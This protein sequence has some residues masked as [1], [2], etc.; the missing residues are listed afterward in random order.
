MA[1]EYINR[2]RR[3]TRLVSLEEREEDGAQFAAADPSPLSESILGLD[4]DRQV[5]AGLLGGRPFP[6][7]ILLFGWPYPGG[8]RASA[9][10]H[11]STISRK[12]DKLAKS[13]RK[14]IVARLEGKGMSRRQAAESIGD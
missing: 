7:G 1:Q 6:A 2:Y 3:Q 5:L 4:R 14:H 10:V 12:L 13:L 11:E 8:D 9:H